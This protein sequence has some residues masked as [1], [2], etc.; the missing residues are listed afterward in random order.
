[1]MTRN[2][3]LPNNAYSNP[4]H[5]LQYRLSLPPYEPILRS[6]YAYWRKKNSPLPLGRGLGVGAGQRPHSPILAATTFM[7]VLVMRM[8]W[9]LPE[10]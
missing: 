3:L 10:R 9:V 1:M 6:F 5:T 2:R 4:P 8:V 7:D